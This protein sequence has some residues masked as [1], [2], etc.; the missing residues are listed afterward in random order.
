VTTAYRGGET[1]IA[2]ASRDGSALSL[3]INGVPQHPSPD[4]P[5]GLETG[6]GLAV[7]IGGS[8]SNNNCLRG[9]IGELLYY[10]GDAKPGP[11]ITA[12]LKTKWGIP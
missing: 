8:G 3:T 9:A 12:A 6:N 1:L 7:N 10:V 4:V 11:N 5:P 2:T